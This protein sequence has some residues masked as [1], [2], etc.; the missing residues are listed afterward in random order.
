ML[1]SDIFRAVPSTNQPKVLFSYVLKHNSGKKRGL[2][3][4]IKHNGEIVTESAVVTQFLA[5]AHQS[6][7]LPPSIGPANAL[8][9]ARL[10]FF[11]DTFIPMTLPHMMA[12]QRAQSESEK[13]AAAEDFVKAVMK[14]MEPLFT[15]D[16]GKGPLF[17]GSERLT[18][19]EV[20]LESCLHE[21]PCCLYGKILD[22]DA[23][24]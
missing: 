15:W 16:A 17:E 1:A 12:G 19:T 2:L 13:D 8:C 10:N 18:L 3:P 7:L 14:E 4:G 22:T 24:C 20:S 5:D 6:H 9:R 11:A 23:S 21:V